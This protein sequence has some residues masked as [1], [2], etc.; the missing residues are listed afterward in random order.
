MSNELKEYWNYKQPEPTLDVESFMYEFKKIIKKYHKHIRLTPEGDEKLR[1]SRR[2]I[3][4]CPLTALA[5]EKLKISYKRPEWMKAAK[6][7]GLTFGDAL[8][9]VN[10][11]D[12]FANY[13]LHLRRR[14][15]E[16][17]HWDA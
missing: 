13:D 3:D 14:M 1:L 5:K 7:L 8:R 15:I 2:N 16:L 4:Y 9:I 17:G 6:E 11:V 10:C 12:K